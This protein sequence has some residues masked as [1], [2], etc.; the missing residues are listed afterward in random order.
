LAQVFVGNVWGPK[1]FLV[2]DWS[3]RSTDIF[4]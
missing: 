2:V 4:S 1:F 3:M